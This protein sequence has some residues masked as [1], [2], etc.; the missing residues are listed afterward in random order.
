MILYQRLEGKR[1]AISLYSVA[2]AAAAGGL[3]YQVNPRLP[4]LLDALTELGAFI[5]A[6]CLIEPTR[7]K[8]GVQTNP[9]H[10]M[11]V[12]VK[13]AVHGH[14]EIAGI[15]IVSTIFVLYNEDGDVVTTTL[16]AIC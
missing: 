6:F 16:Y 13:Y 2:F 1:H 12:T 15:I 4:L 7:M 5:C 14:K 9:I 11:W 10:D 8:R 3:L